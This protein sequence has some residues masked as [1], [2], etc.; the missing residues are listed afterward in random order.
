MQTLSARLKE[1]RG[2]QFYSDNGT[3]LTNHLRKMEEGIKPSRALIRDIN[4]YLRKVEIKGSIGS[5][6]IEYL[7]NFSNDLENLIEKISE[8]GDIPCQKTKIKP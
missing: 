6:E 5:K 4:A 3:K 8:L 2:A 7:K 1:L